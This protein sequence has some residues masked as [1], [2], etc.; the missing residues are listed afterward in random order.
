VAKEGHRLAARETAA[1]AEV[2][3]LAEN[4]EVSLADVAKLLS[5]ASLSSTAGSRASLTTPYTRIAAA[6]RSRGA[7]PPTSS[8]VYKTPCLTVPR[9]RRRTSAHALTC[10]LATTTSCGENHRKI[11][12]VDLSPLDY[13]SSKGPTI[14]S[15]LNG[16]LQ[17]NKINK[18]THKDFMGPLCYKDPLLCTQGYFLACVAHEPLYD[19]QTNRI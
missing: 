18:T 5:A 12:L 8:G 11:E 9:I 10:S 2:K 17:D 3:T 14:Y 6:T 16:F 1:L 4:L 15:C 13:L 19:L 7:I